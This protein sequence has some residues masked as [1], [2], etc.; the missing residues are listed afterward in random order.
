[1]SPV[2]LS[3]C[4]ALCPVAVLLSGS[5]H[6]SSV[7]LP[8]LSSAVLSL[9]WFCVSSF[10]CS[11]SVHSF[12]LRFCLSVLLYLC[13]RLAF[14]PSIPPSVCLSFPPS[15]SWL[16]R[17]PLPSLPLSR[18][19]NLVSAPRPL[20]H[21]TRLHAA[22][23]QYTHTHTYTRTHTHTL[24]HPPASCLV[25]HYLGLWCGRQGNKSARRS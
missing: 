11:M 16:V 15:R 5:L 20:H 21:N 7:C 4:P 25:T 24:P 13:V 19:N 23:S 6:F 18:S 17:L 10:A 3:P 1:M 22:N 14:H 12:C 9:S 8:V 2:W